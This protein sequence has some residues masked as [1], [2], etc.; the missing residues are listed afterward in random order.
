MTRGAR[1][2]DLDKE[3]TCSLIRVEIYLVPFRFEVVVGAM[4]AHQTKLGRL[5]KQTL[6]AQ[7]VVLEKSVHLG[8]E[9]RARALRNGQFSPEPESHQRLLQL[10]V[11]WSVAFHALQRV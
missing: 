1:Q 9:Q 2:A 5:R 10:P 4:K 6:R 7:G 11:K 8:Q 3:S